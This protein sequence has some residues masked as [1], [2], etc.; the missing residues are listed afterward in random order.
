MIRSRGIKRRW[1]LDEKNR[2]TEKD[3]TSQAMPAPPPDTAPEKKEN[4][5]SQ[6]LPK[7]FD[8]SGRIAK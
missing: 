7:A 5:S 2:K 1:Q 3:K 4:M 6:A 8:E